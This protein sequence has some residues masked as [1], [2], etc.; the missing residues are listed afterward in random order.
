MTKVSRI[1]LGVM[2]LLCIGCAASG[3]RFEA[4]TEI[5]REKALVYIYRPYTVLGS[6]VRYHVAA[7]GS[8]IVYL[9]PGGYF[10]YFAEPGEVEFWAETEARESITTDL[11][12]GE[13]YYLKGSVG[14]GVMIGRP[15]LE[16]VDGSRGAE[17]V[18]ECKRLPPAP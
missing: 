9:E 3:P 10:P 2:V 7:Q 5:P 11:E 8:D 17:E 14:I 1:A 12:P 15:R 6:G 13:T 4:V 16:F 18:A